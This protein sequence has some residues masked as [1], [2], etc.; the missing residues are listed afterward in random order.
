M[1][2]LGWRLKHH[3]L[4][5]PFPALRFAWTT[6]DVQYRYDAR[7]RCFSLACGAVAHRRHTY[8]ASR[9]DPEGDRE[10]S[11]VALRTAQRVLWERALSR[12][13]HAKGRESP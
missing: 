4:T 9:G 5:A 8:L 2:G 13:V 10:I 3:I 12:A 6:G 7:M 11:N 1:G